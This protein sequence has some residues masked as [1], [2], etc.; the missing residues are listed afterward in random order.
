MTTTL[1]PSSQAVPPLRFSDVPRCACHGE[2]LRIEWTRGR[3]PG[4][5]LPLS[6][7]TGTGQGY[8]YCVKA[9]GGRGKPHAIHYTTTG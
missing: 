5:T 1:R 6:A 2:P 4:Y 8:G 9:K 7:T 3:G